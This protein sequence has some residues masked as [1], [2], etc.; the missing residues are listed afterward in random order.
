MKDNNKL[1]LTS[2]ILIGL[3]LGL[4]VGWINHSFLAD[5]SFDWGIAQFTPQSFLVEVFHVGGKI[6]VNSLKMMV[7]PLVFVSLICGICSLSDSSKLGR[8]G[9]KSIG[10]YIA[11][12]AVAI[13]IAISIGLAISP[14]DGAGLIS[15]ASMAGKEAPSLGQVIIDMFPSNPIAA[16]AD[17]SMLQII[18]FSVLFGLAIVLSGDAGKR[19][20][21]FF[22][23][24]NTINLK[25]VGILMHVAPYG[26]FCLIAKLASTLDVEKFGSYL[27]VYFFTVLLAL[28]AHALITYPILL[29]SFSGLSPITF[30]RKM[31]DAQ[32]F[33]F[34]T[35]S[36]GATLPITMATATKKL[37]VNN[38]IASFTVPLGATINMDGTAI[39]QGVATVFIAQAY[40]I[41][42]TVS[43][44]LMVILTA[45]LASIGTA[46]VPG[47]GLVML[48]MVLQQVGLPLEGIG[49]I[50]AVDRLLDM[51]RTAVNVTG[52]CMVS[53]II[54]KSEGEL[55]TEIFEN[56][57]AGEEIEQVQLPEAKA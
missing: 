18:V 14:G 1:S 10:L 22:E 16:M 15:S 5:L 24:V 31:K 44:Y 26:V 30:M 33:A 11:T 54:A 23:D 41:D 17:G 38:N 28:F 51:T 34:S 25:L 50:M 20:T 12:T 6:F 55:D 32:L 19:L 39:M 42:L 3:G 43:D 27:L 9:G 52:D 36:S 21:A 37:G 8:L 13:T 57:S 45:T 35:A 49:I 46:A 29:K 4:I 2:R 56:A 48:T 47:V 53:C 7:V 40:G